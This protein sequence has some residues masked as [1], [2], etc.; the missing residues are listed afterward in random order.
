MI[1]SINCIAECYTFT[2]IANQALR[3]VE[4]HLDNKI[5]NKISVE[6]NRLLNNE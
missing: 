3:R 4:K 6:V 5:S 1:I 2:E